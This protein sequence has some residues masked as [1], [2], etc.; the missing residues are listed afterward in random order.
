M[1]KHANRP[2]VLPDDLQ[3]AFALQAVARGEGGPI[4]Q[5]RAINCILEL[6][7][8]DGMSFDEAGIWTDFNEG[9]RHVGRCVKNIIA[10]NI[11]TIA[12]REKTLIQR[13]I[14]TKRGDKEHG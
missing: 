6:S 8:P 14:P 13:F 1:A 2:K 9:A 4:E 12:D 11:N 3:D 7:N 10:G 5:Q